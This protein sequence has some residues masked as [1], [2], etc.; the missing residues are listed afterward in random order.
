MT[1]G[2]WHRWEVVMEVN[3]MGRADGVFR[4]WIDGTPIMDY[5]NVTYIVPGKPNRF[6]QWTWN[7][8][9]GGLNATKSRDDFIDIDHVYMSGV[10]FEP[11]RG[12][13]SPR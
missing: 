7:P 11:S 13:D 12:A 9:W 4:M 8:T 5:H 3:T 1:T 10:P 6:F 2:E